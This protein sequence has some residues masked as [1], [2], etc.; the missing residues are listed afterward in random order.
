[1]WSQDFKEFVGLLNARRVEYLIVGG[2]AVWINATTDNAAKIVEI[3]EEFGFGE[4]KLKQ[5]DFTQ[6][7]RVLQLGQPPFRIDILTAIDGVEFADCF[8]R[9]LTVE[10]EGQPV[11][12]IG[13]EDLKINKKAAGRLKDQDDLLNLGPEQLNRNS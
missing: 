7:G 13:L 3:L 1:M 2:Y 6:L 10:Y 4:F 12:F 11:F 9:R 5:E 8:A